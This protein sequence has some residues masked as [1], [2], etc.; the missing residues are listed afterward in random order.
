MADKKT[1]ESHQILP[2][3]FIYKRDR[4]PYW[5]GY[6]KLNKK[7]FR[8][9]LKTESFDEAQRLVVQYKQEILE[10]PK[11]APALKPWSF[12]GCAE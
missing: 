12:T 9:S 10:D 3:V 6:L 4:S 8:R 5:W 11:Q 7:K 1:N 2:N